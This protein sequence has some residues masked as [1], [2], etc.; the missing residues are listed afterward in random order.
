MT[1]GDPH[2]VAMYPDRL[3]RDVGNQRVTVRVEQG[4]ARFDNVTERILQHEGPD[5][6]G[7]L[8]L[9]DLAMF[10]RSSTSRVR[11]LRLRCI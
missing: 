8:A 7:N 11:W 4:L 2:F 3:W 6:Q 10:S 1:A 9:V 5:L